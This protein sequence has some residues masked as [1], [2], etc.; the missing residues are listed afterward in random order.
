MGSKNLME[1]C[2]FWRALSNPYSDAA[3]SQIQNFF[4]DNLVSANN[5]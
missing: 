1:T 3:R 5:G 4:I 2:P